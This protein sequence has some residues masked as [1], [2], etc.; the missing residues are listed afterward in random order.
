MAAA[1]A[2]L[3]KYLARLPIHLIYDRILPYT[4]RPQNPE[5]MADVRH[6]FESRTA[7]YESEKLWW[8]L[9]DL[10]EVYHDP[11]H[12]F[13]N[14]GPC[15]LAR[16]IMDSVFDFLNT[17][18]MICLG[19]HH[20]CLRTHGLMSVRFHHRLFCGRRRTDKDWI[21]A[22]ETNNNEVQVNICW[23]LL[24]VDERKHIIAQYENKIKK[25][26]R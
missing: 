1:A 14:F 23:A 9:I 16:E 7:I 21:D 8:S 24:T 11:D 15:N 20:H 6:F 5:L 10:H 3:E 18:G 22:L 12:D 19:F 25:L 13:I 26:N 17:H 2:S 4:Y